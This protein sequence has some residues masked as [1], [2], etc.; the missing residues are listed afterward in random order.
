MAE[1]KLRLNNT[2]FFNYAATATQEDFD[3]FFEQ[4]GAAA[5]AP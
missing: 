1:Q 5:A 3:R 4:K 2:V